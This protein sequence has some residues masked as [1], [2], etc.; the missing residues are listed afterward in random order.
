MLNMTSANKSHCKRFPLSQHLDG[1]A[2]T[3]GTSGKKLELSN[4]FAAVCGLLTA[5]GLAHRLAPSR[6]FVSCGKH[7]VLGSSRDEGMAN[8]GKRGI[9][10]HQTPFFLNNI[11]N[12]HEHPPT[13]SWQK[14]I[15]FHLRSQ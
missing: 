13:S 12:I 7:V 2:A 6:S 3:A 5:A 11:I 14:I 10:E 15:C 9:P 4:L 8:V 1:H